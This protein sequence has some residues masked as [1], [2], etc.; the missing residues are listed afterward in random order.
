MIDDNNDTND[1]NYPNPSIS[2][3]KI[4]SRFLNDLSGSFT[5]SKSNKR[6]IKSFLRA[7]DLSLS[8]SKINDH[9]VSPKFALNS[10]FS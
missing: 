4:D 3:S 1:S 8:N 7:E 5:C 9:S 6:I 2:L 10:I